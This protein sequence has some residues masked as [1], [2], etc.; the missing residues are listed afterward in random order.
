VTGR[1]GLL[2]VKEAM[3]AQGFSSEGRAIEDESD[4]LDS[5]GHESLDVENVETLVEPVD[6]E[7][8]GVDA[9][10]SDGACLLLLDR[11]G[12][13]GQSKDSQPDLG[14]CLLEGEAPAGDPPA[15]IRVEVGEA[16]VQDPSPPR[17]P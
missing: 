1:L 11:G 7:I 6:Q 8:D 12:I 15:A 5:A 2:P 9:V 3:E 4:E 17:S 13:R 16:C 10:G 14:E